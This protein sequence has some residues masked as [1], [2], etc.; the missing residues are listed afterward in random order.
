MCVCVSV[1]VCACAHTYEEC[2]R[3]CKMC[4]YQYAVCGRNCVCLC[5]YVCVCMI[6]CLCVVTWGLR[7]VYICMKPM[8]S[9]QLCTHGDNE[10]MDVQATAYSC[11]HTLTEMWP[12]CAATLYEGHSLHSYCSV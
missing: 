8:S 5:V 2:V 12:L 10:A 6:M 4:V 9:L 1:C 11:A 3:V 7:T